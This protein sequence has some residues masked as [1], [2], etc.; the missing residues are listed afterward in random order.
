[1]LRSLRN[2]VRALIEAWEAPEVPLSNAV[3]TFVFAVA[4]RNYL[5][6]FSDRS[7]IGVV[8]FIHYG[9]FYMS[10]AAALLLVLRLA[11]GVSTRRA[12]KVVLPGFVLLVIA[13]IWDIA[14]TGGAG[15]D[16]SYFIPGI[17]TDIWARYASFGGAHGGLGVSAGIKVELVVVLAS[18]AVYARVSG[19]S[20]ARVGL[21]VWGAYTAVFLLGALPF[22]MRAVYEFF[23][24]DYRYSDLAAAR[25]LFLVFVLLALGAALAESRRTVLQIALDGRWLRIGHYAAMFAL[26][27]VFDLP[28]R[29]F[30][31]NDSALETFALMPVALVFAALFSIVTNN[32]ADRGID[33]LSNPK[34]PTVQEGFEPRAYLSLALPFLGVSLAA[35]AFISFDALFAVSVVIGNY[36]VYS[37]P[38]LRIKRL[39]MLS[40]IVIACNSVILLVLGYRLRGGDIGEIPI[41]AV[42]ALLLGLSLAS[43]FIDLKDE[44]G[45]A[46]EG[47]ATLP[48]V[49]GQKTAKRLC[50]AFFVGAYL[51][52]PAYLGGTALWI[53]AG[54]LAALQAAFTLRPNYKELPVLVTH[55]VALVVM[56]FFWVL[57]PPVSSIRDL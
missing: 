27:Y 18:L 2:R 52:V 21:T 53:A 8:R 24:L 28:E 31:W 1:M 35:A 23:G 41:T 55:L 48:V 57:E 47:I 29:P 43:N 22:A 17:H 7:V 40:K 5:E 11:A 37:V 54:L 32:W 51:A 19:A 13:P 9:L 56:V 25:F 20:W 4:A 30:V 36:Y 26:G 14:A 39:F 16:M 38:P 3:L 44:A 12:A 33:R 49:L 10:V 42:A 15:A 34:R 6:V 50:A 45:D 46:A